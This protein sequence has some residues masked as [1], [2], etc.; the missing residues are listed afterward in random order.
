MDLCLL[1]ASLSSAEVMLVAVCKW[2]SASGSVWK[3]FPLSVLVSQ[4][5]VKP[6]KS[7]A[8]FICGSWRLKKKEY[9]NSLQI[10]YLC[11]LGGNES[12]NTMR[13]PAG[14]KAASEPTTASWFLNHI[15]LN[16]STW[17]STNQPCSSWLFLTSPLLFTPPQLINV[18]NVAHSGWSVEL[19]TRVHTNTQM[20]DKHASL[21]RVSPLMA[22]SWAHCNSL[23][24]SSAV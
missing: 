5:V 11:I 14:I 6:K 1:Q 24:G 13:R 8:W 23:N 20:C 17:I 15:R 21:S 4:D 18:L 2:I 3:P 9:F 16:M 22:I 10:F 12:S 19:N 7:C